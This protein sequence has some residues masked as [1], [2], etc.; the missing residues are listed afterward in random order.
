MG[1]APGETACWIDFLQDDKELAR[2]ERR[3]V[4]QRDTI[5]CV[6]DLSLES[7]GQHSR[8]CVSEPEGGM[9]GDW[10]IITSHSRWTII[11]I[12]KLRE[13]DLRPVTSKMG[14]CGC[15]KKEG[16]EE[17]ALKQ[18]PWLALSLA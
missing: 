1:C 7:I 2:G 12:S 8:S 6:K 9:R 4:E 15:G 16:G 17:G 5:P 13:G 11:D 10:Q 18:A 3:A 14:V